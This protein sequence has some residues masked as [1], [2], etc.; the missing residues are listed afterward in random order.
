RG[1]GG[2]AGGADVSGWPGDALAA[3][4]ARL[5]AAKRYPLDARLRG[6]EGTAEVAFTIGPGG[7]LERVRLV[8]SSGDRSLDAA[9]LE[10]VRRGAPYPA[11]GL[12]IE[13]PIVFELEEGAAPR[14]GRSP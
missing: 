10:A 14:R 3:V 11:A 9:A 12:T 8:R 5:E 6:A 2:P 1:G 7:R 13:A 4:R